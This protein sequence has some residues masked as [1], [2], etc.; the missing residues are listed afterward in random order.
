MEEKRKTSRKWQWNCPLNKIHRMTQPAR[1]L[2]VGSE[3]TRAFLYI[4]IDIVMVLTV[5][6][7][8]DIN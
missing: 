2:G 6:Y 8:N 3:L 4:A 7:K 1:G 5:G